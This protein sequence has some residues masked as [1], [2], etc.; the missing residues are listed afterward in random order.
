MVKVIS[1][2]DLDLEQLGIIQVLSDEDR[3]PWSTEPVKQKETMDQ[4][5]Q[6]EW[7]PKRVSVG[8][9]IG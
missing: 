8:R 7:K 3:Y 4:Q 2:K 9:R 5:P 1:T 6:P